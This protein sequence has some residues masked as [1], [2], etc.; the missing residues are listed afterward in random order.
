MDGSEGGGTNSPV[1]LQLT[2]RDSSAGYSMNEKVMKGADDGG[3]ENVDPVICSQKPD[4]GQIAYLQCGLE[5]ELRNIERRFGAVSLALRTDRL[6]L[7]QRVHVQ[8]RNRQQLEADLFQQI[9]QINSHISSELMSCNAVCVDKDKLK[10]LLT[11]LEVVSEMVKLLNNS[12]EAV[13]AVEQELRCSETVE[14][15]TQLVDQLCSSSRLQHSQLVHTR[16]MLALVGIGDLSEQ[17]SPTAALP[18]RPLTQRSNSFD[19]AVG[20]CSI[21][22]ASLPSETSRSS[23]T[24]PSRAEQSSGLQPDTTEETTT[25]TDSQSHSESNSGVSIISSPLHLSSYGFSRRARTLIGCISSHLCVLYTYTVGKSTPG[26]LCLRYSFAA[27]CLLLALLTLLIMPAGS[28]RCRDC[29]HCS[30]HDLLGG[31]LHL[32]H[33]SPPA[34]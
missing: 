34:V 7:Q 30:M 13:G 5:S 31:W 14:E 33:L 21:T 8:Q 11:Q 12:A 24:P 17:T 27:L 15:M 19:H 10:S 26:L 25:A 16:Q 32:R 23:D 9:R 22:T 28:Q 18:A 20:D 2:D 4:L 29:H 3:F 1:L 6:T